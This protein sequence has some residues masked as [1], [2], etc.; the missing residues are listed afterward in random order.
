VGV[1]R[2]GVEFVYLEDV[3]G[4]VVEVVRRT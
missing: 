2:D 3:S 1:H 4:N